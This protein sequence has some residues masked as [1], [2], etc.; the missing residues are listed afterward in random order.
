L[1]Q[2]T[3]YQKKDVGNQ[4]KLGDCACGESVRGAQHQEKEGENLSF[5]VCQLSP[6]RRARWKTLEVDGQKENSKTEPRPKGGG[7]SLR[8]TKEN[9]GATEARGG[10]RGL[11]MRGTRN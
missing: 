11:S 8:V 9:I 5:R 10:G 4:L 2:Q 3:K 1:K 7:N 6:F